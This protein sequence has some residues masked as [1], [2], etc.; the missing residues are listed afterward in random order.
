MT[1]RSSRVEDEEEAPKI[2]TKPEPPK[3]V[4]NFTLEEDEESQTEASKMN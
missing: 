4:P 2:E 1:Q 3:I